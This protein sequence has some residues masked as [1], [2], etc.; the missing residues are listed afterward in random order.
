VLPRAV[1][2]PNDTSSSAPSVIVY[3]TPGYQIEFYPM[4]AT[5]PTFDTTI[6]CR[7]YTTYDYLISICFKAVGDNFLTGNNFHLIA[8]NEY[9]HESVPSRFKSRS[10]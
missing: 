3:N 5:D 1:G 6:D 4:N 8:A 2:S 9:R 10:D 7:V